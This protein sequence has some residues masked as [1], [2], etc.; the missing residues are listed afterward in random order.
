MIQIDVFYII[1]YTNSN[2]VFAKPLHME[3]S[4]S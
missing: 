3:T 1:L 4:F 2:S